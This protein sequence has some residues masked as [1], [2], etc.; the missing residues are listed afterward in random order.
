[1]DRGE[2]E[3]EE[4]ESMPDHASAGD[5]GPRKKNKRDAK[6]SEKREYFETRPRKGYK[7]SYFDDY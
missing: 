1:M 7:V 4:D 2:G 5:L 6:K 3:E